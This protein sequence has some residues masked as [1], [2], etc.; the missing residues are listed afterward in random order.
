MNKPKKV[1]RPTGH[2]LSIATREKIALSRMGQR[3]TEETK[4]KISNAVKRKCAPAISIERIMACDLNNAYKAINGQYMDV[5]IPTDGVSPGRKMRYH[6]A[7]IEKY[8]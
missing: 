3:H 7:L 8:W 5:Y 4:K 1:G 6:V 2:K